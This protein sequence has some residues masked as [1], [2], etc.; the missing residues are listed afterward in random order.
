MD[1]LDHQLGQIVEHIGQAVGVRTAPGLDIGQQRFLASVEFDDLGHEGINRL[2]VGDPGAR[3]IGDGHPARAIDIHQAGYAQ[4]AVWIEAQWIEEFVVHPAVDHVDGLV[5]PGGAHRHAAVDHAQIPAFYQF[6]THLFGEERVFEIGRVEDARREHRDHRLAPCASGRAGR[7]AFGEPA[8]I[9]GDRF[10][11]HPHEQFGEHRHH[12][13]AVLQH[14][15]DPAGGAGVVF[16]H[17][18]FVRPGADQIDADDMGVDPAGRGEANH[19][20]QPGRVVAEQIL[21]H[22]SGADDFL[23]VIEIMHEGVERRNALLDA[24]GQLAPFMRGDD[25]RDHVERNEPLFGLVFAIDIEGDASAPERGLGVAMFAPQER[26]FLF[27]I[28]RLITRIGISYTA[29][30]LVHLVEK[31]ACCHVAP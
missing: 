4:H 7:Q 17:E 11:R 20:R 25:S 15:G 14:V 5:A 18:E 19:M 9:V 24:L 27:A 10:D 1:F 30:G 2:I 31:F 26:V 16:Q 8:R 12:R 23:A 22:P 21:G 29:V 6:G 28:P 13:L 3:R